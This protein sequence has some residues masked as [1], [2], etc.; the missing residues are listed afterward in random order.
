MNEILKKSCLYQKSTYLYNI[1][2]LEQDL[3]ETSHLKETKLPDLAFDKTLA[4]N[5]VQKIRVGLSSWSLNIYSYIVAIKKFSISRST[6]NSLGIRQN[7]TGNNV[8]R[9]V[10]YNIQNDFNNNQYG[11]TRIKKVKMHHHLTKVTIVI[12][13][14][15]M[16]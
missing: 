16:L 6:Y 14:V 4:I 8:H 12:H 9:L 13:N 1:T 2:K 3:E 5:E 11:K 10:F 15:I 7:L